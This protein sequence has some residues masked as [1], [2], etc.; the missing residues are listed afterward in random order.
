VTPAI[1]E[2]PTPAFPPERP[3]EHPDALDLDGWE[4]SSAAAVDAFPQEPENALSRGTN[5]ASEPHTVPSAL[6]MP[7]RSS[8]RI[9][10][11]AL[12]GAAVVIAAV[13]FFAFRGTSDDTGRTDPVVTET[14]PPAPRPASEPAPAPVATPPPRAE[15]VTSRQ[16][17]MRVMVDG[18]KV[19]EREVPPDTRIPLNP[20]AQFVVRAG[21][22]GAVKVMIDGK[23]QGAFGVDGRVAT[24]AFTVP[25]KG[26]E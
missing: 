18:E 11:L 21:D 9:P 7:L 12:A 2:V 16:V 22:A 10:P 20:A 4:Q 17:W 15:I 1:V 19:I 6:A 23:D 25:P 13:A 14:P 3:L 24:R 26:R 5:P 8:R